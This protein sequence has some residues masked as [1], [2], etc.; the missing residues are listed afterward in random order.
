LGKYILYINEIDKTY[1]PYVGGKGANLG[2]M[3]KAGFK[4][5]QGFCIS[6][7][8][9]KSFVGKS[10]VMDSLL[11]KLDV[12][13]YDDLEQIH[14]LGLNIREHLESLDI[15]ADVESGILKAWN[16]MGPN[17]AYA[18]RSSATAEDLPSASFAGQQDT[19]LNVKGQEQLLGAVQ[20][21]WASLF[22]DR[23]ISYRAKNRFNHRSVLLSVV[24]Q[25]MIFPEV[26]GIMFTADPITGHR[27]TISIDASF[28]LGEALVSGLVTADLYQVRCGKIIKRQVSKKKIEICRAPDGGTIIKNLPPE[29]QQIQA[30]PDDKIIEL[31][32]LGEQ[33]Q[34]HY[35][36]EQDIEWCLKNNEFYIVQSRPIT[37]LYP[38]PNISDDKLHIFFSFGHVQMMTEAMK[39]LGISV[40]RTLFPFGKSSPKA[41]SDM[42]LEAGSRLY[43]DLSPLLQYKVLSKL[44]PELLPNAD[45]MMAR[46]LQEFMKRAEFNTAYPGKRLKLP[47]V[48]KVFPLFSGVYKTMLYGKVD[49]AVD[50]INLSLAEHLKESRKKLQETSGLD[51][52]IK[53]REILPNLLPSL[54]KMKLVTHMGPGIISYKL[55]ESLCKKWLEDAPEFASI[56]KSPVGNVTT[57]MS[58]ALGDLADVVRGHKK[59]VEYLEHADNITFWDGL[60]SASEEEVYNAFIKFFEKYGM[61]GTGEIDMTRPR[62]KE[63]PTQLVPAILSSVKTAKPG[64]HRL[65]FIAGRYEGESAALKLVEHVKKTPG[66]FLK[67]KIMQRLLKVHRTLIALREHP[68]FHIVQIFD[69]VKQAILEEADKLVD[70]GILEHREEI[71][72]FSLQEIQQII[73]TQYVDRNIIN[74]RKEKFEHDK[75]LTPPRVITSEGEIIIAKSGANVPQGALSG[76]P[77]SSG[78][79]EGHARVVLK[80]EEAKLHK[81]DILVTPYTDPAW[82]PLFP[83]ASGLVTEVGGLMTHGA[84]VAREYGIPAVVGIDKATEIIKDGAF[85]RVNGTEGYVQILEVK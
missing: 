28:G 45:E 18:V 80:L 50:K 9:Y 78:I 14:R 53:I 37:S 6:T 12:V 79:V 67:A 32:S 30:L 7:S 42:L 76:S 34:N 27:K 40:L 61:R 77:A 26:S 39:P 20:K 43:V 31:A 4:V 3:T 44:L 55:I 2:E 8:A 68:K 47:I 16:A 38:V 71:C 19:Y 66:G 49:N 23:A 82:T 59:A 1:L 15:P 52:I 60:K 65:D 25:Q 62:W 10:K 22:T 17:N 83:L 63:V 84:V 36:F 11:H 33:I 24:V 58:L 5:P 73:E 51:R 74:A 64:Q 81:G 54:V 13:K 48:P 46:A 41:D 75:K 29:K 35:S 56:S 69:M 70:E 21:C 57:E 72:W 85:I